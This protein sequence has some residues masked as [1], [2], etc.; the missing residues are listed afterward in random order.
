MNEWI[1]Q[2]FG[3]FLDVRE[4]FELAQNFIIISIHWGLLSQTHW[5]PPAVELLLMDYAESHTKGSDWRQAICSRILLAAM[6][7]HS[8]DV[9][10]IV[11]IP[12]VTISLLK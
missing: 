1:F 6:S 9:R 4:Y 7:F 11:I 2:E 12:T 10:G 5:R 8:F 3:S